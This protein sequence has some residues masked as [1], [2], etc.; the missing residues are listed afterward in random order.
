MRESG[1]ASR[2]AALCFDVRRYKVQR[3]PPRPEGEAWRDE[4]GTLP[5]VPVFFLHHTKLQTV[6]ILDQFF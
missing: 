3:K 1:A 2:R 6:I 5:P 4:T